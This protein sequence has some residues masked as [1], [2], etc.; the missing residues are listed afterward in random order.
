MKSIFLSTCFACHGANG[1]GVA[2]VF[3][4]LA[5]SDFLEGDLDLV[6]NTVVRGMTG[7]VTVNGKQYNSIM[8]PQPLPD[9]QVADV[10]TFVMNS[11]GNSAEP[12]TMEQVKAVRAQD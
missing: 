12:V 9:E 5:E 10:L 6:I 11:W 7:P 3:P 1:E 4:P 2:G 8:P